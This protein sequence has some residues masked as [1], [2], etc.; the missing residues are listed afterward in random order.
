MSSQYDD[1]AWRIASLSIKKLMLAEQQFRLAYT[2]NL[3]V[4]NKV[5]T[6]DVPVVWTFGTHRVLYED[7]GLRADQADLAA[8]HLEMTATFVI[9]AAIRDVLVGWF[10]NPKNHSNQDVFSAYQITRMLRNAF[11]HSM[12][13]P[14]W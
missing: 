1:G 12:L 10:P 6:L 8:A 9:A 3:A 4:A 7:F 14:R 13:S 11:S 5:Q 2:V